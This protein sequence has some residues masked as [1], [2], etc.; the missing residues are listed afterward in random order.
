VKKAAMVVLGLAAVIFLVLVLF[1]PESDIQEPAEESNEEYDMAVVVDTHSDTLLKITDNTNWLPL[2]DIGGE[3]PFH[4]DIPK[5]RRGGVNVQYF[6][7]FTSGYYSSGQPDYT[8]ANSRLLS[9]FNALYWTIEKNPASIGLAKTVED[10]RN[11]VEDGRIS[12]VLSIEGAYSIEETYGIELLRQY[13]DLGVRAVGL[14]WNY[15]NALG[16]GVNEA[17]M[18]GL[19]SEGGLTEFG[20][21]VVKNMNRLGI[22][23]DISHMN[24]RTFWDVIEV[25]DAPVMA[26]HSGVYSLRNHVRNL[27]DDQIRAVAKGGGVVQVVFY[28]EFLADPDTEVTVMTVVDHIEYIA[29]L[30]GVEYVGIGSD[31][32]GAAMPEDLQDASMV[33]EIKKELSRRGYERDDIEKILGENTMRVMKEAWKDAGEKRSGKQEFSITPMLEMGQ[34]FS[35][36]NPVLEAVIKAGRSQPADTAGIRV[37]VDGR[38][39]TPQYYE[40]TGLVSLQLEEPLREKFHVVTFEAAGQKG[41]TARET[42]IFHIQR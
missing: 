39:Y 36:S 15:S 35:G 42:R 37:I 2:V 7:A 1:P 40:K 28:P 31:F 5:L 33:P 6:G 22:I 27:K 17:Y 4:I 25:S 14:T 29:E 3:T 8:K 13:Y 9:L 18:D 21:Q 12:A 19:P 20:R 24:E 10:I 26:S 38:V 41:Y 11:L 30:V 16:E 23:V 32:D 34:G